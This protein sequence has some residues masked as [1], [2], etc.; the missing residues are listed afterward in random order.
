MNQRIWTKSWRM[1]FAA[2][3][4][5]PFFAFAATPLAAQTPP[6]PEYA[7]DRLGPPGGDVISLAAGPGSALYLGT[8]DGHVFASDDA[9]AHWEL[10]GRAGARLDGVVQRLLVDARNPLHLFAAVWFQD[11]ASGGGVFRSDDA[12]RTWALAGLR[13]EAVRALEQS[14][15]NPEVLTAGARSGVFRS[16]DGGANW[17][18][19]S[20]AGDAELRNLDSLAIDPRDARVIYAGT[21]HLP[22]KTTDAGKS[23]TP[24]AAGMIDDSDIMSLRI[25]LQNPSRL[26]SSA[27]SGIYRSE[28]AGAQWIKLQ[29]IP[30]AARRTQTMVQD[31]HDPRILYAGTTE[32]LWVSRDTGE[33]W[34]RITPSEWVINA[35]AITTTPRASSARIVLGTEQQGV[36]VSD[37]TGVTFA[38][39]NNGF[40]HRVV[41]DLAGDPRDASHLLARVAGLREQLLESR[42]A[43]KAWQ[44]FP[45]S[46]PGAVE[47]KL[48]GSTA[49]WWA[50]LH[51]GGL[52]RYDETSQKWKKLEFREE[53]PATAPRGRS[54]SASKSRTR[55]RVAKEVD[56]E[57]ADVFVHETHVYVATSRGVW[58]GAIREG[59]LRPMAPDVFPGSVLGIVVS[60]GGQEISAA[61]PTRFS[62]SLD[63]GK[64]WNNV[65]AP[66]EAGELLWLAPVPPPKPSAFLSSEAQSSW[67]VGT[68]NGVY[69]LTPQNETPW[70]LLESGLPAARSVPP[71]I[72][73]ETMAIP[74]KAGGLYLTPDQGR[75]WERLDSDAEAGVITGIATDG[76]GGYL[77]GSKNEGILHLTIP[78]IGE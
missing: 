72:S 30:Y 39:A 8:A 45:A 63:S 67:L 52:A 4:A 6:S 55:T 66:P 3:L 50:A 34:T 42:D 43:G 32:G 22:W 48:Y 75:S 53:P 10:R 33:T 35:L 58:S 20:P 38:T 24:V 1:I 65:A 11:P 46:L 61:T 23:W 12:G 2:A 70:K 37:D 69:R 77:M 49:G 47:K 73:S 57:V 28:N 76:H 74:M 40:S 29:G 19:I 9:A 25:D 7:W 59:P 27:C 18:R 15:S 17:Q 68:S 31:A 26:F 71:A 16:N 14:A 56:P 5:F 36:L 62:Q 54:T 60:R 64:T 41:A 44:P 21:Y 78:G 13:G 51:G